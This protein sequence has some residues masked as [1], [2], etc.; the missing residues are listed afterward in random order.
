MKYCLAFLIIFLLLDC[1]KELSD[2]GTNLNC[3]SLQQGL[4]N[5]DAAIV[6]SLLGNLLDMDY[7]EENLIKLADT[8]SKSC[9][10]Q[11][12]LVC[13][14]CIETLPAQS[15]ITLTFLDNG[16]STVRELDFTAGVNY[17]TIKLVGVQ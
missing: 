11:A 2:T 8:I 4:L 9:D 15:D 5:N 7:S 16:D 3:E 6:D 13:F 1:N 14:D 10:I 17:K 12:T